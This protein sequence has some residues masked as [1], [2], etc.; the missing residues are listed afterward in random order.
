MEN[1]Q[2]FIIE[3]HDLLEKYGAEISIGLD[4]DTHGLQSWIDIDFRPEPKSWK[5]EHVIKIDCLSS[6]DLKPFI[7]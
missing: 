6:Y 1:K 2:Q 5:Y 7:K 4:G 3:L